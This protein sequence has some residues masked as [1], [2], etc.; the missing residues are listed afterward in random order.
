VAARRDHAH[1]RI[2]GMAMAISDPEALQSGVQFHPESIL[3]PAG[4][5]I[6]AN[7]V[8]TAPARTG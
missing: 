6:L 1:A 8:A 4:G 3:T 2:D 5:R 7:L